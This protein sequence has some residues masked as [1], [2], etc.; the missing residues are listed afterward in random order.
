M[1][2]QKKILWCTIT[3]IILIWIGISV[4]GGNKEDPRSQLI[5][6][7]EFHLTEAEIACDACHQNANTSKSADDKLVPAMEICA[8]CHDVKAKEQCVTCHLTPDQV[9]PIDG[10]HPNYDV[11]SHKR[12]TEKGIEC[13]VCHALIEKSTQWDSDRKTLPPMTTC[14]DCH[15]KESQTLDCAACHQGKHPQPGDHTFTEWTRTHGL[16]AA[17]NPEYYQQYFELGY[18]E[19]CHQG[20]NLKGEVHQPEWLFVHGDEAAAGGDCLV[21]HEDRQHCSA[22]HRAMI[23]VPHPMGDPSFANPES[24][25]EHI[26]E[27]EAFFE[28]C[29]SCHDLGS[30]SPTCTRCH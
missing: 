23:P 1:K 22:C 25:G 27:A 15:R 24:G 13:Q 2:T 18:C 9:K 17:F 29:L 21:C 5:F 8:E 28:A 7:H 14:V 30:A 11:F 19:N 26:G 16:E 20:L 6:N 12:H 4:K 10:T 3:L